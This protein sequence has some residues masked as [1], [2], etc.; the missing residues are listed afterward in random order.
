MYTIREVRPENELV[1]S[2]FIEGELEP[3]F[4]KRRPGQFLSIQTM[5][6]SGWSKPHPFTI[7]NAPE[8]D[9]LQM[10]IKNVGTFTSAIRSLKPG[11]EVRCRGPFGSFCSGIE[12]QPKVVMLAGG[13]GITPFLSVLRH[14]DRMGFSGESTLIWANNR[15]QDLFA[16][17]ELASMTQRSKF[18]LIHV[19]MEECA[20][21]LAQDPHCLYE[22]GYLTPEIFERHRIPMD[23]AFYLCGSPVMQEYALRQLAAYGVD[24]NQVEK[25]SF[26]KAP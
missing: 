9:F 24:P 2:L 19:I 13:I 16:M 25:E 6:E 4:Q 26:N 23:A 15:L 8:D 12:S 22:R 20:D 1:T 11:C 14:F 21:L 5:D 17:D 7:S 10:T 3:A 18:R